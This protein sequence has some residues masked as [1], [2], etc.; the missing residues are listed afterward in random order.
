MSIILSKQHLQI[1]SPLRKQS[2]DFGLE[3]MTP[4]FMYGSF[5]DHPACYTYIHS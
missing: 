4:G 1:L 5:L 2:P 3:N